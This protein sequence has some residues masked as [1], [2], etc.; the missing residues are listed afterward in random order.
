MSLKSYFLFPINA[1]LTLDK[2]CFFRIFSIN[3]LAFNIFS[4]STPVLTPIP[5]S[6]YNTSSVATL[7][8]APKAY[9]QPPNPAQLESITLIPCSSALYYRIFLINNKNTIMIL[10]FLFI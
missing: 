6:I 9:G 1:K 10:I 8:L 2:L 4:I 7:P 5:F 3:S